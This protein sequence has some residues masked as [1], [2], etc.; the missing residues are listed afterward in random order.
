MKKIPLILF[1]ITFVLFLGVYLFGCVDYEMSA[2]LNSDGSGTMKIHYWTK[3]SNLSMGPKVGDFSF[4]ENQV[5]SDYSSGNTEVTDLKI[6]EN[7]SDSTKHVRLT[8]KFKDFNKIS[9]AKGFAKTKP[10]WGEGKEDMEFKFVIN[11][12]EQ[13]SGFTA[14]NKLV[15]EFEFPGEVLSTN[16]VKD[17]KKVTWNKT[18]ADLKE[19]LTLTANI[20]KE[21]KKCGI[22]GLELP[23]IVLLGISLL[24][25]S[26][27]K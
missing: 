7:Q 26:R 4:E 5:K 11:K 16:G 22:F 9:D 14:S 12:Q 3:T 13:S 10:F 21:S 2:Q 20:K 8:V 27:K 19:D 1:S 25:I 24:A 18:L 15:Y 23:I 17:G 6:E